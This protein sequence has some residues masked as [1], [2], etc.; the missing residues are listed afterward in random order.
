[1]LNRSILDD[2]NRIVSKRSDLNSNLNKPA[3]DFQIN[4]LR[5]TFDLPEEFIDLF[6]FSNGLELYRLDDID[7]YKFFSTEEMISENRILQQTYDEEWLPNRIAFCVI[8]G[9]GNFLA[10]DLNNN[11][12]LDGF[13]EDPPIEW[14]KISNNLNDFL[15]ELID[16]NGKKFWLN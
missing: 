10:I 13:H 16:L 12:I 8:L 15:K 7:G 3:S 5:S 6:R 2:I 14:N 4:E 11:S 1:M 9:E